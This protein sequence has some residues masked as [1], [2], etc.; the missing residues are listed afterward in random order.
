MNYYV[1]HADQAK[2]RCAFYT[3]VIK[4]NSLAQHYRGGLKGF[5][6]KHPAKCN[7]R[8]TVYC[9]MSGEIDDVIDDLC[10][11]G[12]TIKKDFVFIDAGDYALTQSMFYQ[13]RRQNHVD[14]G[15]DWLKACYTAA[16]FY[17][18]HTDENCGRRKGSQKCTFTE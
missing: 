2:L 9:A 12:L 1:V 6:E 16:G 7:S 10:A 11:S 3:V 4:N 17:V 8:I 14:V 5:L 15:V 13:N 18:W